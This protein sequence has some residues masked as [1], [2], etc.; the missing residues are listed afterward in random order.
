MSFVPM[1]VEQSNRGDRAFDIYSRLLR[2][3]IV[4]LNGPIDDAMSALICA[5]LLFLESESPNREIGLYINSPGGVVSSGFAIYDTM[6]FISS[7]VSTLCMGSACSAASFLL[8]AGAPG[9]RIAL[10]N[11]SIMLH[12]PLGGFQG[13]ASDIE[14][15]AD[16]IKR[17]KK[18]LNTLYAR[19]CGRTLEEVETTL[20]RDHFMDAEEAQ[21]WGIVDHV[22][23]TRTQS[24]AA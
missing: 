13:S 1:V 18:R 21:A 7:P 20:D 24:L 5:Q 12:Q 22:Y 2:E 4:F 3:R 23:E 8:M 9:R 10:P 19:H 14:R 17:T 16:N 6:Q 15:H 11:A